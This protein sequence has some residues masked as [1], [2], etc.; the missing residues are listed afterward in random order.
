M[1]L[2]K[3]LFIRKTH[4]YLG[5]F[6]G[7]Q[8]L[9]WTISGIYFSWNSID[10]VHGDHLRASSAFISPDVNVASPTIAIANLKKCKEGG[11]TAFRT[12]YQSIGK[13]CLSIGLFF[14]SRGGGNA[15]PSSLCPG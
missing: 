3:Q 6:I 8:F 12:P 13:A 15:P 4:R 14:R 1:K 10:N 5:L 9:G 2:N 7:I 11:L